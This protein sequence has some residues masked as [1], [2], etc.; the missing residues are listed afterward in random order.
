MNDRDAQLF[1][2]EQELC[3]SQH[4]RPHWMQDG[5]VTFI[6][7]RLADSIPREV[8][9]RW[10]AERIEFLRK[11]GVRCLNWRTGRDKLSREDLRD[12][13]RRFNRMREDELDICHGKCWLRDMRAAQ[14]VV[15]SLLKFDNDRY[16]MGDLIVMVN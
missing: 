4:D 15:D 9:E 14:I 13:N 8:I 7:M 1:D 6:T 2:P 10:D 16:L 3:I 11:R 5:T 12:F